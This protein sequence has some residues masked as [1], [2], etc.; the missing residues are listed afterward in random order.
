MNGLFVGGGD[1]WLRRGVVN[2][3]PQHFRGVGARLEQSW[4]GLGGCFHCSVRV[5]CC[6]FAPCS[7]SGMLTC[8][9]RDRTPFFWGGFREEI[10]TALFKSY[11]R[12]TVIDN[13]SARVKSNC[14]DQIPAFFKLL[15]SSSWIILLWTPTTSVAVFSFGFCLT[16][17]RP[18]SAC[19]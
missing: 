12:S 11:Q 8:K 4:K 17:A 7:N 13:V 1:L 18:L 10:K 6:P 19:F 15:S 14:Q 3:A 2:C 9:A 5:K 16:S